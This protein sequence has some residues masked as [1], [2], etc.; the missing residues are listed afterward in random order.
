MTLSPAI[1]SNPNKSLRGGVSF[2]TVSAWFTY[3]ALV[4]RSNT[5]VP[6][7]GSVS[8]GVTEQP[9]SKQVF[10]SLTPALGNAA[11]TIPGDGLRI[12][13]MRRADLDAVLSLARRSSAGMSDPKALMGMLKM[14]NRVWLVAECRKKVVGFMIYEQTKSKVVIHHLVTESQQRRKNIGRIMV[15]RLQRKLHLNNRRWIQ[16]C[17]HERNLTAQL[18]FRALGF[19]AVYVMSGYFDGD[20][21]YL[22]RYMR[23]ETLL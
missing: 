22:M 23:Q 20:D 14:R 5:Q 6:Y 12:R 3:G 13:W 1:F 15:E 2:V 10:P 11:V 4:D 16:T 21:A 9:A 17:V 7:T 19:R 18:F 8:S